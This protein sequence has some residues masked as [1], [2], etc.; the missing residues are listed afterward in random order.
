[1]HAVLSKLIIHCALQ[2]MGHKTS[3]C[4][5]IHLYLSP[6]TTLTLTVEHFPTT[7]LPVQYCNTCLPADLEICWDFLIT[8]APSSDSD[9]HLAAVITL[10]EFLGVMQN[11]PCMYQLDAAGHVMKAGAAILQC[12]LTEKAEI[13][14]WVGS[15]LVGLQ[16]SFTRN[17]TRT[18][19][20]LFPQVKKCRW[21]DFLWWFW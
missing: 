2:F 6:W 9:G 21:F 5:L 14:Y 7:S 1:M 10:I 15:F 12:W 16:W 8:R 4:M 11:L 20:S 19:V 18:I 3:L 13:L 17:R